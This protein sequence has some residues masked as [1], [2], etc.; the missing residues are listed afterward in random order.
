MSIVGSWRVTAGPPGS[1]LRQR[2]LDKV[3]TVATDCIHSGKTFDD[4]AR[5]I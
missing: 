3:H 4:T 1:N 5:D 2:L